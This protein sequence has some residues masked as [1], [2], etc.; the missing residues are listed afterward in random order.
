MKRYD[1]I[2]SQLKGAMYLP[3]DKDDVVH[4][5]LHILE[6]GT[7]DGR[8]AIKMIEAAADIYENVLYYG[9]DLFSTMTL[10]DFEKEISK[11]V[12]PPPREEVRKLLS[13]TGATI[14]LLQGDSKTIMSAL[15][16]AIPLM[17]FIFIDG[18]HSLE[19]VKSDWA[20]A[21]LL[22]HRNTRVLFDDYYLEKKDCGCKVTVDGIDRRDYIVEP[23]LPIE[24]FPKTG[25]MQ[26]INVRL[27]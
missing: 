13:Q 4:G 6:F 10:D 1:N 27:K 15:I 8:S 7:Y 21:R 18:G 14:M 5:W 19:T 11:S 16:H 26:M 12:R 22:M 3:P 20:F 24:E 2:I 23:L 25:P 9:V 17:D